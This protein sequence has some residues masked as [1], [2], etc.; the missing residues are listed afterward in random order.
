MSC[1]TLQ[2]M[3]IYP[4]TSWSFRSPIHPCIIYIVFS[5]II[6]KTLPRLLSNPQLQ[7]ELNFSTGTIKGSSNPPVWSFIHPSICPYF[8]S[9]QVL[10]IKHISFQLTWLIFYSSMPSI[11]QH[12]TQSIRIF[13]LL[14]GLWVISVSTACK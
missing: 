11:I 14:F 1:Q 2:S 6:L 8:K 7:Q 13:V 9:S 5:C 3:S 4:T 10:S 12:I